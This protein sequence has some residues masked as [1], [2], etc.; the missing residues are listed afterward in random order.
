WANPRSRARILAAQI[1][2]AERRRVDRLV[3]DNL[4]LLGLAASHGA[5]LSGLDQD[6]LRQAAFFG[7]RRA[8]ETWDPT[9]SAF[10]TWAY[11]WMKA[12]CHEEFYRMRSTIRVPKVPVAPAPR[13]VPLDKPAIPGGET[14]RSLLVDDDAPDATDAAHNADMLATLRSA[15][16]TL[17]HKDQT[18]IVGRFGLDGQPVRTFQD[19]GRELGVSGTRARQRLVRALT[20]LRASVLDSTGYAAT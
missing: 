18:V 1:N 12:T 8:A 3:R 6:D 17:D 4:H 14:F 16:E 5:R 10:K 11:V 20:K 9:R 2:S 13:C 19:L 15:V 7:L